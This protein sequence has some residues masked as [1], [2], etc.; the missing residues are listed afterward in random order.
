MSSVYMNS[1]IVSY[2]FFVY[3]VC[4]FILFDSTHC[5][6]KEKKRKKREGGVYVYDT[7]NSNEL[8]KREIHLLTS[9]NCFALAPGMSRSPM[10]S[11]RTE[12]S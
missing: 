1:M 12:T 11:E 10:P 5:P 6:K 2:D 3:F 4:V 8:E 9:T 7:R